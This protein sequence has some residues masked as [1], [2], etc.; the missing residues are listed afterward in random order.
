MEEAYDEEEFEQD[1]GEEAFDENSEHSADFSADNIAAGW[2]ENPNYFGNGEEGELEHLNVDR[3][4]GTYCP[5]A[6]SNLQQIGLRSDD[7]VQ[8]PSGELDHV[9]PADAKHSLD[10][11]SNLQK[12]GLKSDDDVPK[13][14]LRAD[15][16]FSSGAIP[17]LPQIGL[18]D[19]NVQTSISTD[20]M[21]LLEPDPTLEQRE[22]DETGGTKSSHPESQNLEVKLDERTSDATP[23]DSHGDDDIS[24]QSRK[25]FEVLDRVSEDGEPWIERREESDANEDLNSGAGGAEIELAPRSED[26]LFGVRSHGPAEELSEELA[27]TLPWAQRGQGSMMYALVSASRSMDRWITDPTQSLA[28]LDF[29]FGFRQWHMGRPSRSSRLPK[30]ARDRHRLTSS[31]LG[32][33]CSTTDQQRTLLYHNP[34]CGQLWLSTGA[35]MARLAESAPIEPSFWLELESD[36]AQT[37][38]WARTRVT[39]ANGARLLRQGRL[40][41]AVRVLRET[42]RFREQQCGNEQ[43][44]QVRAADPAAQPACVTLTRRRQCDGTRRQLEQPPLLHPTAMQRE[45]VAHGDARAQCRAQCQYRTFRTNQRARGDV[46]WDG[47]REIPVSVQQRGPGADAAGGHGRGPGIARDGADRGPLPR[48]PTRDRPVP[49]RPTVYIRL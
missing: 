15:A 4:D 12:I 9:D 24:M 8:R 49:P 22:F 18:T 20:P 14:L 36:P 7:D 48:L 32:L 34:K 5:D 23:C 10:A 25:P 45:D 29:L 40:V 6:V 11:N 19:D 21:K 38:A 39:E 3:T 28:G 46:G 26:D 43:Y 17:T 31:S 42:L 30:P 2:D 35:Y 27:E 37:R 33:G 13:D 1:Y 47:V 44:K 41:Q 16:T